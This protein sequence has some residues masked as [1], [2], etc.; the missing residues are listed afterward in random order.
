MLGGL[1][2]GDDW[3]AKVGVACPII[4]HATRKRSRPIRGKVGE[5]T[6]KDLVYRP[7]KRQTAGQNTAPI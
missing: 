1:E 4:Q 5:T 3:E 2:R 6:V 7:T